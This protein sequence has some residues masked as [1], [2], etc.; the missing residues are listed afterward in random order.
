MN[1]MFDRLDA[2]GKSVLG[3]TIQCCQCHNHK[4]DPITHEEYYKLFAFLNDTHEANVAVYPPDQLKERADILRQI[5]TIE[6]ELRHQMPDWR[7]KMAAGEDW[8]ANDQPQWSLVLTE[9]DI[10]GGQKHYNLADGSILAQGYAPTK[11]TTEFTATTN[12]ENI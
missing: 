1:A 6:A 3:L 9:P 4:Y 10:S 11:H 2:I 5:A 8:V 12:V 7:E